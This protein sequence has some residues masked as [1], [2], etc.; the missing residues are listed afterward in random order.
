[1]NK[2]IFT[3]VVLTM[4][5][6]IGNVNGSGCGGGSCDHAEV[7][8]KEKKAPN[9]KVDAVT[10]ATPKPEKGQVVVTGTLVCTSCSLKKSKKAESQCSVYGCSY[11]IKTEK[12]M[13]P[14]GEKL[15]EETGVL[16]HILANDKSED[17]LQANN[18]GRDVIVVGKLYSDER[19]IEIDFVKYAPSKAGYTCSMCGGDFDK[20]GKCPKCGMKLIEKKKK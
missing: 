5:V 20:P 12:V 18:K 3:A 1:M 4:S 10:A 15:K 19:V 14:K 13:S 11:A 9:I 6:F 17:L 7:E 2:F 8:S 16:F